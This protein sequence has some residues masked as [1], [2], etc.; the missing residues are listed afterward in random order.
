LNWL[1]LSTGASQRIACLYFTD[2]NTGYAVGDSQL[3]LKTTNA[4]SNW[5]SQSVFGV[6]GFDAVFFAS[7]STGYIVGNEWVNP[8]YIIKKTTNGGNNWLTL[9]SGTGDPLFDVFFANVNTGWISGYQGTILH[10]TNGGVTGITNLTNEIPD[11]FM[12]YQNY[13]NPFNPITKINSIFPLK[14]D[15]KRKL[16]LWYSGKNYFCK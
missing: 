2:A 8:S 4:G 16:V 1:Q 6:L 3:I 7:P 15:V 9:S 5:F 10:T 11:K 14:R 12:L 13:P